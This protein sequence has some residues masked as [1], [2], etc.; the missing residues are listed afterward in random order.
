[1]LS[2]GDKLKLLRIN[3]F[4]GEASLDFLSAVA[5]AAVELS[6]ENGQLIYA[7]DDA[8][9]AF[10]VLADG[11]VGHPEAPWRRTTCASFATANVST[12]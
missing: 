1:M 2:A 9:T 8:A 5:A 12:A 3:S 7:K 11:K 6:F 10:Y 4:V